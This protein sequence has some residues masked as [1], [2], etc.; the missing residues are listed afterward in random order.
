[1]PSGFYNKS[2][3]NVLLFE[4]LVFPRQVSQRLLKAVTEG[5]ID[6]LKGSNDVGYRLHVFS[7]NIFKKGISD[8]SHN[9]MFIATLFIF[10]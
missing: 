7:N 4:Q 3:E 8:Y 6:R 10:C 1:M 2:Q 5:T 9:N